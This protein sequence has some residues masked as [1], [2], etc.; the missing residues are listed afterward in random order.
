MMMV[1]LIVNWGNYNNWIF[2]WILVG[3]FIGILIY[4]TSSDKLP[5]YYI[6]LEVL[7]VIGGLCWNYLVSGILIDLLQFLGMVSQFP[8]VYLG[9]TVIGIGNALND[10][11]TTVKISK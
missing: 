8:S 11:I 2:C 6:L 4:I 5:R 7:G 1:Y 3:L 9:L 10:G